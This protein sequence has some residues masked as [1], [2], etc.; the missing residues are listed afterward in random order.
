MIFTELS[1]A[2]ITF[3]IGLPGSGK[4]YLKENPFIEPDLIKQK[5]EKFKISYEK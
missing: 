3:V 4:S 5:D 1:H 2:H